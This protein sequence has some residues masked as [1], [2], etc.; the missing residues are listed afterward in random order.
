MSKFLEK[1]MN[2]QRDLLIYGKVTICINDTVLIKELQSGNIK[3]TP[4]YPS[5]D[6]RSILRFEREMRKLGINTKP[7]LP[8]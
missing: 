3:I 1:I 4:E 2:M 5:R 7:N 6:I 8:G